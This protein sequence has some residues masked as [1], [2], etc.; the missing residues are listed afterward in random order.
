MTVAQNQ[1]MARGNFAGRNYGWQHV[2]DPGLGSFLKK[3]VK[4]IGKVA[5][6][7]VGIAGRVA[8]L[9]G[10]GAVLGGVG[11][12]IATRGGAPQALPGLPQLPSSVV[13]PGMPVPGIK[14]TIQR[15]IPGGETGYGAPGPAPSGYRLNKSGYFLRDGTFVP[16]GTRYVR[17]RRRNPANPRALDRAMSRLSSAKRLE[18]KL[19]RFTIKGKRCR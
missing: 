19:G 11:G 16:P 1:R 6:G 12:A 18:K 2:G 8:G 9:G 3:A 15:I 4:G 5:G 13:P 14:G 7:V 10:I 17:T